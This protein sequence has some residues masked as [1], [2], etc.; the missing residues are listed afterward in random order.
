MVN[1]PRARHVNNSVLR[2]HLWR[3]H[4]TVSDRILFLTEVR[5]FIHLKAHSSGL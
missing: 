1:H 4:V 3:F 2:P 5:R